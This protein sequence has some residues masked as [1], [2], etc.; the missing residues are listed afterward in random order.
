MNGAPSGVMSGPHNGSFTAGNSE[1]AAKKRRIAERLAKLCLDYD[2]SPSQQMLLAVVAGHLDDAERC[3]SAIART[4]ATNAA[5]RLLKDI[6]RKP[7]PLPATDFER[8]MWAGL[9]GADHASVGRTSA[10]PRLTKLPS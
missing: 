5:R 3:R 7:E 2:P 6:A 1:R 10:A 8:E 9:K 4:R